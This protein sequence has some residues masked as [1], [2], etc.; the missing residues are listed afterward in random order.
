MPPWGLTAIG[1]TAS[2]H[3]AG[4]GVSTNRPS[5]QR[6][7][8]VDQL[9]GGASYSEVQAAFRCSRATVAKIAKRIGDHLPVAA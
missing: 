4:R 2:S 5:V 9:K 7:F 6:H 8:A 1:W 3:E